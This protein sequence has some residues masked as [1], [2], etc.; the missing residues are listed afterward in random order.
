M[1]NLWPNK[2]ARKREEERQAY[3]KRV[4]EVLDECTRPPRRNHISQMT[5]PEPSRVPATD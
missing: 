5:P 1:F 2:K 3:L 4:W